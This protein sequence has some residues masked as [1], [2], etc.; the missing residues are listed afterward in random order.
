VPRF[1]CLSDNCARLEPSAPGANDNPGDFGAWAFD[2]A[3]NPCDDCY[4]NIQG[5]SMATPQVAGVAA[6]ALAA[7]PHISAKDLV[8]LL[9]RSVTDFK[10]PNATPAIASNPASPWYNYNINYN[11]NR[12]PNSLMGTGVIDATRAV[13]QH[14][15]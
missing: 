12:I 11:G 4:V 3:G 9:R 6:L 1:D 13:R 5:T 7:H 14:D 10:D 2:A 15:E 8:Q